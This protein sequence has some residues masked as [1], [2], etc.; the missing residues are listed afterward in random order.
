[1]TRSLKGLIDKIDAAYDAY[2]VT[3]PRYHLIKQT[4]DSEQWL[5]LLQAVTT[6]DQTAKPVDTKRLVMLLNSDTLEA[7]VDTLGRPICYEYTDIFLAN[8]AY[9]ALAKARCFDL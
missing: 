7:Y 3:K 1:M 6:E 5:V 2:A 4:G 8:T 9:E